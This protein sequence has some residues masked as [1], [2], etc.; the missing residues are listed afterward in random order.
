MFD[1]Q[2]VIQK[3]NRIHAKVPSVRVNQ[4]LM[5][6]ILLKC[7]PFNRAMCSYPTNILMSV[8]TQSMASHPFPRQSTSSQSLNSHQQLPNHSIT[9]HQMSLHPNTV[10]SMPMQSPPISLRQ[11]PPHTMISQSMPQQP[12]DVTATTSV[13]NDCISRFTISENVSTFSPSVP[14]K[15]CFVCNTT[16]SESFVSLYL[17]TS[18][19]SNTKIYDFIWSLLNCQPSCRENS[20]D[21]ANS[22]WS[23]VCAECLDMINEYDLACVKSRKYKNCLRDKLSQTET[24]YMKQQRGVPVPVESP[25]IRA[26]RE[27]EQAYS[28]LDTANMIGDQAYVVDEPNDAVHYLVELSDGE[29]NKEERENGGQKEQEVETVTTIELSDEEDA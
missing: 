29:D 4:I 11:M 6:F 12:F 19:H 16:T 5:F 7:I 9:S 20:T 28:Y 24:Y 26:Q 15:M 17:A 13:N 23:L 8:S 1:V 3:A 25:T 22:N 18:K 2:D 10:N 14:A 21:A 27:R